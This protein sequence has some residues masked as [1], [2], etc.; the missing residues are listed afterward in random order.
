MLIND[1]LADL[2][3]IQR[4]ILD[5]PDRVLAD[6]QELAI[7]KDDQAGFVILR[8]QYNEHPTPERLFMLMLT[9][10][11]N[12]LRFNKS[13]KFNQTF[14]RRTIND[15]SIRK[16]RTWSA[17]LQ[18]FRPKLRFSSVQFDQ[19]ECGEGDFVYL[20][21]PYSNSQAGYNA[22]WEDGDDERLYN[23]VCKI[24]AAGAK[25]CLSGFESHDGQTCQLL[26]LLKQKGYV[27]TAIESSYKKVS[28]K[29]AKITREIVLT[30]YQPAGI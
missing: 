17:A 3:E 24:D 8:Q 21:P 16:L 26:M 4:R 7:K 2:I 25:F 19:I 12:M 6:L 22:F 9:C 29:G 1:V 23:Y 18:E 14:G 5:N 30:N 11:N 20:D 28:R 10:T 27:R 13:L 15:N